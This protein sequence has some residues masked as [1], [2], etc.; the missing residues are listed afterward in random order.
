MSSDGA[1]SLPPDLVFSGSEGGTQSFDVTFN[2]VGVQTLTATDTSDVSITGTSSPITVNGVN[3]V[4]SFNGGGDDSILENAGPQTDPAWATN[5]NEGAGDTGQTLNFIVTNTNNALFSVQPAVDASSG[6]LTYTTAPNANG[7]ATVTVKLHDNGGTLNGGVDT[8]A[9]QA[10]TVTVTPV[11]Q[12][13]S[14]TDPT[15]QTPLENA[16]SEIVVG[17]A[18]PVSPGPA[19]ESS[20]TLSF[21]LTGAESHGFHPSSR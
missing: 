3:Q 9:A 4:P 2:T 21:N 7:M 16:G 17:L 20:Q 11:N 8:S 10:M 15:D 18:A 19:N 1:A 6:D 12:A 5:I 13:P 14:F